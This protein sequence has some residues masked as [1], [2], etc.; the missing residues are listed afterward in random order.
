MILLVFL[1]KIINTY[2]LADTHGDDKSVKNCRENKKSLSVIANNLKKITARC[3][4]KQ[5]SLFWDRVYYKPD[6]LY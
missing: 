5:T 2:N 4:N 6:I 3:T 1:F